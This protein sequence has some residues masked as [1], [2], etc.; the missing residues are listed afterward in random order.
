MTREEQARIIFAAKLA[1]TGGRLIIAEA[2][3]F[4]IGRV[5][6]VDF[7]VELPDGS[8][9]I[10]Y[11]IPCA[12]IRTAT[13][14]EWIAGVLASREVDPQEVWPEADYYYVLSFD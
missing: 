13:R 7:D 9:H 3:P 4:A 2:T 12:A 10:L 5:E 11:D 1:K 14:E 8:V 6:T